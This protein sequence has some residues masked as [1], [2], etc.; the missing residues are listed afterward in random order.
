MVREKKHNDKATRN[1]TKQ[2][3]S[4]PKEGRKNIINNRQPDTLEREIEQ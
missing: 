3:Q 1:H 2:S 4:G